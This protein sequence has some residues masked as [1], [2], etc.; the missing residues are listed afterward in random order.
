VPFAHDLRR[1][2]VCRRRVARCRLEDEA[3]LFDIGV[4]LCAVV[5]GQKI[6]FAI[7]DDQ[8]FRRVADLRGAQ[9]GLCPSAS[10]SSG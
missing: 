8:D 9:N 5:A 6:R 1:E 2:T 3:K 4:G 10:F 7:R